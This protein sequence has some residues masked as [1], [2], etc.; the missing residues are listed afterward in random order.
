MSIFRYCGVSALYL[1]LIS[2]NPHTNPVLKMKKSR[3]SKIEVFSSK[4]SCHYV[5]EMG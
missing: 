2:F 1:Y 4:V 3:F 5:A